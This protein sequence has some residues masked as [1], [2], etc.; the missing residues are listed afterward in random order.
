MTTSAAPTQERRHAP[1]QGPPPRFRINLLKE[2]G[3][4]VADGVNLSAGGLCV[5]LQER[6]EVRSLIRFQLTRRGAPKSRPVQGT[7]RV[8]WVIQRLDL[9]DMPPFVF[10]IGIEFVDPPPGLQQFV[11]QRSG[12]LVSAGRATAQHHLQPVTIRG[13]VYVPRLNR[14]VDHPLPWHLVV[15]LSETPCFSGHY[16]SSRAALAA[17]TTFQRQQH[18]PPGKR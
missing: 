11:A 12:R 14:Q 6:L 13:R 2:S 15:T 10:D 18:R 17:W 16:G 8:A 1:R 4:I 9:R 5:R 3:A 7:G